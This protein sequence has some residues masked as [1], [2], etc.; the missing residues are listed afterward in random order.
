[1]AR[2]LPIASGKGGVGKSAIAANLGL[3]LTQEGGSG[4]VV[5][6]VDLDLGGSNLHTFLGVR[7]KNPGLGALVWKRER[8]LSDL[9]VETGFERLWLIP[10]D[11]LLPGTANLEWSVKK[12]ILKGLAALP[13]D[14][15]I[16]DLG[17]GSTYNVVDFFLAASEGLVVIRPEITSVLNAYAFL[18]T[19][20]FRVLSR[21]FPD[22][23]PGRAAVNEFAM[24]KTEGSGLS[25][26]AFAREL[27]SRFPEGKGAFERLSALK[28]R[29]VLN[30]GKGAADAELGYRLRDIAAKNLGLRVEFSGYILEDPA[31]PESI[32]ARKPLLD[33]DSGSPFSRGILAM[34]ARLVASPDSAPLELHEGGEDISA[35]MEESS[36]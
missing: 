29:A 20:A 24:V 13:A 10:G 14:F 1:M 6:L 26:L 28:P 32:A 15:V 11:G 12:R 21:S 34:A 30:M 16:L 23:S 25:F 2:L 35:L 27:A 7:N 22:R 8:S 18:K 19:V 31:L 17:A 4:R 3:A 36:R 9:L 33:L 5:V